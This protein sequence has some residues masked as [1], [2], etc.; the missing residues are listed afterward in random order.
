MLRP[1]KP[2]PELDFEDETTNGFPILARVAH[3]YAL[4]SSSGLTTSTPPKI[5][6][7]NNLIIS[8]LQRRKKT[9]CGSSGKISRLLPRAIFQLLDFQI[10]ANGGV[11]VVSSAF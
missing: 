8:V 9:R 7:C 4:S 3:L 6:L 11:E 10:V 1:Q 2:D 5:R